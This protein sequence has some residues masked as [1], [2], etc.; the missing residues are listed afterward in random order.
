MTVKILSIVSE[1]SLIRSKN[2]E[3]DGGGGLLHCE[4]ASVFIVSMETLFQE[5]IE[6]KFRSI[7]RL[8][9]SGKYVA[10]DNFGWLWSVTKEQ[11]EEKFSY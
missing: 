4:Q 11:Y 10:K 8:R 9:Q 3:R 1:H 6:K 7:R 5:N 2:K